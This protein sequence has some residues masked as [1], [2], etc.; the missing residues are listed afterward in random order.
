MEGFICIYVHLHP[1]NKE[2]FYVGIG[3]LKR[4]Y[5]KHGRS[6]EWKYFIKKHGY[7]IAILYENLIWEEAVKLEKELINKYGR[8]DNNTGILL[9]KSSGGEGQQ[10]SEDWLF[11]EIEREAL[12][13][14][15]RSEFFNNSRGAYK[16]AARN[17][18]LNLVCSHMPYNRNNYKLTQDKCVEIALKYKTK[19]E[20]QYKHKSVY[21]KIIRMKW[22]ELCF[23]HM[24][25]KID[26][27]YCKT[28]ALKFSRP[29][30]L[31]RE[32]KY[33]YNTIIKNDWKEELFT[34]MSYIKTTKK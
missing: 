3:N 29:T 27:Q 17:K 6:K 1:I 23:S 13:Y 32:H 24:K 28:I 25:Q 15:T 22:G 8:L 20:L 19:A 5:V 11:E 16:S 10:K 12:K 26:K 33:V 31:M 34:H 4:P 30:D 9:N 21:N 2:P 14:K 18:I 7:E